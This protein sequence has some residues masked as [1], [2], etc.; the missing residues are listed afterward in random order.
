MYI[1]VYVYA[2]VKSDLVKK[3][4]ML[5]N[6]KGI[7]GVSEIRDESDRDGMRIVVELKKLAKPH[8]ILN[9]LYVKTALQT[10]FAGN[11]LAIVDEGKKPERVTLKRAL[12]TFIKFRFDTIQ[13]RTKHQLVQTETRLHILRG[14]SI[15]LSRMEE[16]IRVIRTASDSGSARNVLTSSEFGLSSA[17]ADALLGLRLGRLTRLESGK[18]H[19]EQ[20]EL[21][22]ISRSLSAVLSDESKV[23]DIIIAE[24]EQLSADYAV[25]RRTEIHSD[26]AETLSS[27]DLIHNDRCLISMTTDGYIKRSPVIDAPKDTPKA[28]VA[29][30]GV[31]TLPCNN[32]DN[33]IFMTDR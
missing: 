31:I 16:V 12:Q 19:A 11:M 21:E 2:V 25:P 7:E 6:D 4:A 3:M 20:A 26:E 14:L 27:E 30:E 24:S 1:H 32:L 22:T 33:I 9:N 13:R 8:V 28:G 15:A 10:R 5:V 18:V 29:G 17:Q 23:Y